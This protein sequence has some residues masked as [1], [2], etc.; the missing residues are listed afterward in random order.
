MDSC[1][2]D[3]GGAIVCTFE[4]TR[5]LNPTVGTSGALRLVVRTLVG[6]RGPSIVNWLLGTSSLV[7][8]RWTGQLGSI[9]SHTSRV[10]RA[11]MVLTARPSRH[12][13]GLTS[14]VE[15]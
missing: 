3:S 2:G 5:L 13:N 15:P 4:L 10:Y 14:I 12:V 1:H 11:W 7:V 8:R 9:C 6:C